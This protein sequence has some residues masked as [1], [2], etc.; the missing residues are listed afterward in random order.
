MEGF[1]G[2]FLATGGAEPHGRALGA[3]NVAAAAQVSES[4]SNNG[5][6]TCKVYHA[7]WMAAGREGDIIKDEQTKG[8]TDI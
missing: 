8:K 1:P 2:L 5:Y 3:R 7:A 6:L 4:R